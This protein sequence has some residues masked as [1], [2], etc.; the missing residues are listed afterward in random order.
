MF[1]DYN[2]GREYS[3]R[4]ILILRAASFRR[5]ADRAK[6]CWRQSEP[7]PLGSSFIRCAILTLSDLDFDR[8]GSVI[9]VPVFVR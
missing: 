6:S 8:A 1:A 7:E 2:S 9:R 3:R 4:L 5:N